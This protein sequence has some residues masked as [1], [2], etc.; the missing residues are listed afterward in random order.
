MAREDCTVKGCRII[1]C[2]VV[3]DVEQPIGLLTSIALNS[4]ESDGTTGQYLGGQEFIGQDEPGFDPTTIDPL[5]V[6]LLNGR[7]YNLCGASQASCTHELTLN[8]D[9]CFYRPDLDADVA[10]DAAQ[11]ILCQSNAAYRIKRHDPKTGGLDL[12]F[13]GSGRTTTKNRNL[14]GGQETNLNWSA[15]VEMD[16][17]TVGFFNGFH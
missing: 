5:Q 2:C 8:G 7:Y 11:K 16:S 9:Y 6:V 12:L 15:T 1:V 13:E 14:P 17:A 3:N 10:A 4:S